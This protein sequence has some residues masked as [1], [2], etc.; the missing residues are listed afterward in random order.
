MV[1]R[2]VGE[3]SEFVVKVAIKRVCRTGDSKLEK[4]VRDHPGDRGERFRLKRSFQLFEAAFHSSPQALVAARL[5]TFGQSGDIVW[6]EFGACNDPG[7]AAIRSELR[8]T[9]RGHPDPVRGEIPDTAIVGGRS[10]QGRNV[11]QR[12]DFMRRSIELRRGRKFAQEKLL[13]CGRSRGHLSASILP[14]IPPNI[15]L[16]ART[17]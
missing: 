12:H 1:T 5:F 17:R 6:L 16:L 13:G 14:I 15:I 11:K 8:K 7:L 9:G 4:P 10:G 3:H 2:G